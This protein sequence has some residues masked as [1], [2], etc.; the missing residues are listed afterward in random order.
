MND[1]IQ[2]EL[3]PECRCFRCKFCNLVVSSEMRGDGDVC[4]PNRLLSP[5]EKNVYL[6]RAIKFFQ[7]IDWTKYST[8]LIRGGEVFNDFDNM[9][10]PNLEIFVSKISNA[11]KAK[12]INRLILVTSLKYDYETSMLKAMLDMLSSNGISLPDSVLVGTS[13]DSI[14]RF[15]KQALDYWEANYN[16]L[17]LKSIPVHITTILTQAL[18]DKYFAGDRQVHRIMS[19]DFD[20][21]P[22]QGK[23]ELLHLKDFFPKR[24]DCLK[25]LFAIQNSKHAPIWYRLLHQNYRRAETIYFTGLNELQTR[26]LET[27]HSVLPNDPQGVLPCGHPRDYANYVDSDACFLCD[28][29]QLK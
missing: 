20:L 1:Q 13:W 14:Y 16:L 5:L 12:N 7:T 26:D 4:N 11:I 17:A 21:I 6:E 23:P 2:I 3:W 29:E 27:F 19:Y 10:L 24:T 25:F 15:N 9:L 28:L 8:L 22:A 18:I